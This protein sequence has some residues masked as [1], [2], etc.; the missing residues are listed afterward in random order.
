MK[1]NTIP[2]INVPTSANPRWLMP[3]GAA[4]GIHITLDAL[5]IELLLTF[6][7]FISDHQPSFSKKL[8][9]PPQP[10]LDYLKVAVGRS[11]HR[12]AAGGSI[13]MSEAPPGPCSRLPVDQQRDKFSSG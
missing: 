13:Q 6:S 9:A 7:Q 8:W 12:D 3:R 4:I 2:N 11:R 10:E 1:G 5:P